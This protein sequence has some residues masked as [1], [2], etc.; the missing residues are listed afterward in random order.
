MTT[1][2]IAAPVQKSKA[3]TVWA[4]IAVETICFLGSE[5]ARFGVAVWIYEATQSVWAFAALLLA[6][7]LP[8]IVVSPVAG[9]VVDRYSRK[10]VMMGS[11]AVAMCGTLIVLAGASLGALSM[12]A[13]VLG[14]SLASVAEAFQWPA[15]SATVPLMTTEEDLPRYNGLLESGRAAAQLAGPVIGGISIAFLGLRGLLAVEVCTFT[16]ATVVVGSLTLPAPQKE[17]DD[18]E[19][20]EGFVADSLFG[21]RWIYRHK[22]LL[23]FLYIAVFGNFFLSIG[24]VLMPPY[25]LSIL[26]ERSYGI[27]NGAFGGGMIV[28]GLLYG[29]LAKRY[30]NIHLFLW[31]A[32]ATGALYGAF[33]FARSLASLAGID[34]VLAIL[35]TVGNSAI[36]TVWQVKV[37]EDISGRV[38]SAVHMIAFATGPI[39]YVLAGPLADHLV[40]YLF[41]PASGVSPWLISVWGTAKSGQLGAL[42]TAM[43]VALFAGFVFSATVRDVRE[44]EERPI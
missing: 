38:L 10:F 13:V 9:V 28:G 6:N 20:S 21:L 15:L 34:F 32:I 1:D 8:G 43:G 19:E 27:A 12:T 33:G 22:A 30:K 5:I 24:M 14:A 35:M 37:P 40:P 16:I 42:F 7:T 39:A 4:L 11:A 29:P 25:S 41:S 3:R 31:T 36:L 26:D 18:D 44:V 23:K 17:E 2:E